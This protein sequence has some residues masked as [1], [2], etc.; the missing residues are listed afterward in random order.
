MATTFFRK[1]GWVKTV[2]GPAVAGA[3]VYVCAPQP[4]NVSALPPSPLA[5]IFSDVNGLVPITQPIITDGFGHY[6]Y[7]AE[8]GLYTEVIGAAGIV[9]QVY[10]DQ[11][12]GLGNAG[13]DNPYTAGSSITI[14]GHVISA[15][16]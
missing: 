7:Y 12:L 3:Q 1:D 10:P 4:A 14:V 8:A 6:D 5:N 11:N 9:Q 15:T 13:P 2:I 16:I